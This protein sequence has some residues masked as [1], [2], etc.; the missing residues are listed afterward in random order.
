M[1]VPKGLLAAVIALAALGGGVYWSEKKKAAE[2]KKPP[3]SADAAPKILTIPPDQFK[4]I[5]TSS[6]TL[7]KNNDAWTIT[8][9][10]ALAADQ[11][12]V[13][14]LVTSLSDLASDRLIE[15]KATNLA[16]YG[17]QTPKQE[18]VVTK[19]DGKTETLLLG[20]DSP[21][22]SGT[23]AKL[24]NDPRV[25]TIASYVKTNLEGPAR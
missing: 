15:D 21:T 22:A 25:F 13:S 14:S 20:D 6:V 16:T 23:Y 10:K 12:A 19:K 24:A 18:I 5:K 1:K 9:P 4:Q 3:V 7:V 2:D 11:D 17:L 8:E